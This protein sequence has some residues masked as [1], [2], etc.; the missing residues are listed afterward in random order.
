MEKTEENDSTLKKPENICSI[1]GRK[2]PSGEFY[3]KS[4]IT[5]KITCSNCDNGVLVKGDLLFSI[6]E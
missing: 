2:I 1:C 6:D 5:G 4:I 3:S